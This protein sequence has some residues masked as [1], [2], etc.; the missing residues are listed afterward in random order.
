MKTLKEYHINYV[1]HFISTGGGGQDFQEKKMVARIDI[2]NF[3]LFL[4]FYFFIFY[5]Y[6]F[7]YG[8]GGHAPLRPPVVPPLGF[9]NTL[10]C[11]YASSLPCLHTFWHAIPTSLYIFNVFLFT[12]FYTFFGVNLSYR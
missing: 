2:P 5:F 1:W 3:F 8:G 6:Y 12:C 11:F 7:F 9:A 10:L 4:F